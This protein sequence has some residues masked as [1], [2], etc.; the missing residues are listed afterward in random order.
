[1]AITTKSIDLKKS[2]FN[3]KKGRKKKIKGSV[4]QVSTRVYSK[5]KR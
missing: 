2:G 3:K 4:K 5:R 1:M